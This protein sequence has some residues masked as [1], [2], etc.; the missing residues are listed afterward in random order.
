MTVNG[1]VSF[2]LGG[3]SGL[4][5]LEGETL[6]HW[7]KVTEETPALE[8]SLPTYADLSCFIWASQVSRPPPPSAFGS[9]LVHP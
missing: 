4:P 5:G 1:D 9:I 3:S 7:E 6:P 2:V 8:M